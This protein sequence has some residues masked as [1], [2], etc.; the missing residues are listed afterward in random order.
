MPKAKQTIYRYFL[1][2]K[3][4]A[5]QTEAHVSQMP[6]VE[7]DLVVNDVQY[8]RE[9]S[10]LI[11]KGPRL[12]IYQLLHKQAPLTSHEIFKIYEKTPEALAQN[13]FRSLLIRPQ[14]PQV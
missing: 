14:G 6:P 10:D 3:F 4:F 8:K 12:W 2:Q 1:R 5:A 7:L 13:F 9:R 11:H